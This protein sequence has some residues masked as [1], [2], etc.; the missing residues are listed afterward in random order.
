MEGDESLESQIENIDQGNMEVEEQ[1]E[2][3]QVEGEKEEAILGSA[4]KEE[5]KEE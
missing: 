2:K 5:D 4:K 3:K 1:K